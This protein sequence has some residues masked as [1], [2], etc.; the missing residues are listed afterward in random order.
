MRRVRE[1]VTNQKRGRPI[2]MLPAQGAEKRTG[3]GYPIIVK[4]L[5]CQAAIAVQADPDGCTNYDV[6]VNNNLREAE[7]WERKQTR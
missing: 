1:C 3:S 5:E 4:R 7:K 6:L 2:R